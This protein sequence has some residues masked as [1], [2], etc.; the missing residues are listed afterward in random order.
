DDF[1]VMRNAVEDILVAKKSGKSLA[2]ILGAHLEG[3]YLSENQSGAQSGSFIKS[4]IKAEYE[5]LIEDYSG[6][7]TRWTYAPEKD[8]SGE[9]CSYLTKKGVLVSAGHT[10]AT[11]EDMKKAVENGCNL[12]THLYSCTSTV[13]RVKGFRY[14]G[15]IE[16]AY[17]LDDVFVEI[18]ADG[19]H[20]PYE[21]IKMIVKIKGADKVCL[22]KDSLEIAGSNVEKGV[23]SGVSYVVSDGVCK[24]SDGT[25]FAGS[26]A[27]S[28]LLIKTLVNGCGYSVPFAVKMLTKTPATVMNLNKGELSAGKDADVIVFDDEIEVSSVFVMGKKVI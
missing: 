13:K 12:V 19:K 24:L 28:N 25:G 8:T 2:N 4:P 3:P 17:L 11:Y 9:F 5:K 18:I 1:S 7:V 10:D 16:S 14:L 20:L 21:L 6:I 23:M 27:T 26:I 22:V 15:V